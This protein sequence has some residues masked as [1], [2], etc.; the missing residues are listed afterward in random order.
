MHLAE[1]DP[2]KSYY[3]CSFVSLSLESITN[4]SFVVFIKLRSLCPSPTGFVFVST[5]ASLSHEPAKS[6]L[7]NF[8]R[9]KK[10]ENL[11][12]QGV[13]VKKEKMPSS[14][15][16]RAGGNLGVS[17]WYECYLSVRYSFDCKS[18]YELKRFVDGDILQFSFL[19]LSFENLRPL[20]LPPPPQKENYVYTFT[21]F[22]FTFRTCREIRYYKIII[23]ASELENLTVNYRS[24]DPVR[25]NCCIGTR[26]GESIP[27][28]VNLGLGVSPCG[29]LHQ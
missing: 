10:I 2:R 20:P 6:G 21:I 19:S 11:R 14:L 25:D 3:I 23:N 16:H 13:S 5:Q 12:D 15:L 29:I 4:C 22:E 18:W 7:I 9:E 27:V 8:W 26:I 24:L 17:F 1:W 28:R